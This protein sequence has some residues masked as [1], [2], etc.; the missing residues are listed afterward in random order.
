M[1]KIALVALLVGTAILSFGPLSGFIKEQFGLKDC[2]CPSLEDLVAEAEGKVPCVYYDSLGIPTI[3][4][5]FNLQRGDARDLL[6][7]L[8]LDY[9]AVLNGDVCLSDYQISYIFN[10]DIAWAK[11]GARECISSF[12]S[13]HEC[14]QEVVTDM[15]F[16][17]G[18]YSLCDWDELNYYL[19][20]HDYDSASNYIRGT[21]YCRQV[22]NRCIRNTDILTSCY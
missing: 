5:G 16:N 20:N 9:D 11:E 12:D 19:A 4:I 3:G 7:E 10:H 22:G 8:G 6:A 21:L 14:V 1:E 18:M 17:M 15:T 2:G 13:H